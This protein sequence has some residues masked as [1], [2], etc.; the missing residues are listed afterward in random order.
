MS[1]VILR[2]GATA[3]PKPKGSRFVSAYNCLYQ[4]LSSRTFRT[5]PLNFWWG[6]DAPTTSVHNRV[7]VKLLPPS[8]ETPCSWSG[9]AR[10]AEH[11]FCVRGRLKSASLRL[12]TV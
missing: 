12:S 3:C 9:A 6:A 11:V 4:L 1:N 10:G 2:E 7:N 8:N 5:F